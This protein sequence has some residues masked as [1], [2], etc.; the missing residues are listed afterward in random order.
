MQPGKSPWS[1]KPKSEMIAE[2]DQ[3]TG[4]AFRMNDACP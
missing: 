2:E 4:Q 1:A 3:S